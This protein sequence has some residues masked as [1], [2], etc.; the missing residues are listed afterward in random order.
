[1]RHPVADPREQDTGIVGF[2]V[3]GKIMNMRILHAVISRLERRFITSR[4]CYRGAPDMMDMGADNSMVCSR[5]SIKNVVIEPALRI[6]KHTAVGEVTDLAV[7]D[8]HMAAAH[9]HR[10]RIAAVFQHQFREI[11]VRSIERIDHRRL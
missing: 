2:V 11:D 4:Q 9:K 7:Q 3:V 1:M 8:A 5:R 10:R 6:D